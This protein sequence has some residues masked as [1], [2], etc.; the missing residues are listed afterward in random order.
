MTESSSSPLVVHRE[1]LLLEAALASEMLGQGLTALRCY[2][3]ADKGRFFGG[4][5]ALT[6]GLER[7]LKLAWIISKVEEDGRFPTDGELRDVGHNIKDLLGLARTINDA[8][9]LGVDLSKVDDGLCVEIVDLLSAFARHA[10][11]YNINALTGSKKPKDEEPLAAWDR[12]VGVEVVGRHHQNTRR[13]QESLAFSKKLSDVR[14][15][16]VSHVLEDGTHVTDLATLTKA[17]ALRET[18]QK[19]SVYY[20][21]CIVEFA[22]EVLEALDRRQTPSIYLFEHFRRF[23]TLDRKAVLRRKKWNEAR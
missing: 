10:R 18:K 16:V 4:M 21:L 14:G 23:N 7:V 9:R 15:I 11:Y 20:T 8:K 22:V 2:T 12:V 17:S 13:M 5:F 3:F 19:Y 1:T 6:V